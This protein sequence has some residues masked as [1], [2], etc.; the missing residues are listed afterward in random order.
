M[1]TEIPCCGNCIPLSSGILQSEKLRWFSYILKVIGDS[2]LS[3]KEISEQLW[4]QS[5]TQNGKQP[6]EYSMRRYL[7]EMVGKK[8][9]QRYDVKRGWKKESVYYGKWI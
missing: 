7:K 9:V 2:K 8:M 3:S 4:M 6:S 5:I 1:T